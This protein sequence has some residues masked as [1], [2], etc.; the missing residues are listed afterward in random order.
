MKN[1]SLNRCS[2]QTDIVVEL[3]EMIDLK[4]GEFRP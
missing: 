1:R 4:R 2:A 3:E